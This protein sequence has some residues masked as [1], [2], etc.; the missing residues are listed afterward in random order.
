MEN[1]SDDDDGDDDNHSNGDRHRKNCSNSK[2]GWEGQEMEMRH[3][4]DTWN[5][6]KSADADGVVAVDLEQ[7][8]NHQVGEGYQAKFVVRQRTGH[9]EEQQGDPSKGKGRERKRS[10][11]EESSDKNDATRSSQHGK[12]AVANK[13]ENDDS[14][15][16]LRY[17]QCEGLRRFRL[18]I[19]KIEESA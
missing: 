15:P 7:F 11:R 2:R 8:R 12:A 5:N 19:A 6:P 17:L 4:R 10:K 14:N 13:A 16:I 9:E 3:A 1:K 18:E